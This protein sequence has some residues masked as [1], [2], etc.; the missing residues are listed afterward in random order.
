M[1]LKGVFL[2]ASAA[3]FAKP[4]LIGTT[5]VGMGLASSGEPA[6]SYL[7]YLIFPHLVPAVC[8]LLLAVD[9]GRY[10]A[11]KPLVALVVGGSLLALLASLL[12]V[13]T[14]PAKTFLVSG[15][16]GR[17][18][19]SAAAAA[20]VVLVD[21]FSL[22]VLLPKGGRGAKVPKATQDPEDQAD[23]KPKES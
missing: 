13:A 3:S 11:F 17:L 18:G 16:S 23:S 2:V 15:S 6:V 10:A 21:L 12:P 1:R 7:R 20:A 4:F 22:F 9:E 14:N 19:A 8:F 5:A